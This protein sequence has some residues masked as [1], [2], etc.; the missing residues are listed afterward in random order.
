MLS[1]ERATKS[2]VEKLVR[3][4][5]LEPPRLAPLPPQSSVS[6]SSTISAPLETFVGANFSLVRMIV[7][8][9]APVY[10]PDY[11]LGAGAAGSGA[12]GAVA[13]SSLAGAGISGMADSVVMGA[14]AG[15]FTRSI[16]LLGPVSP[17]WRLP[18]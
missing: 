6:T 7:G 4:R 10:C 1:R 16:T 15:N 12:A 18:R 8:S 11:C 9:I 13:G 5:G 14:D 17:P 3:I 2:A